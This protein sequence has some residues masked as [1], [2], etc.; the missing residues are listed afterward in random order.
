M[1]SE[2]QREQLRSVLH[3]YIA[4]E[5]LDYTVSVLRVAPSDSLD[6]RGRSP[7]TGTSPASV[8]ESR[9]QFDRS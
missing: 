5:A 2:D 8:H 3:Q 6:G 7:L 4:E 1:P 9:H